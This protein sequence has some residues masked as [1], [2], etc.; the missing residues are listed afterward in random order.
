MMFLL[1]I[2]SVLGTAGLVAKSRVDHGKAV[3][4]RRIAMRTWGGRTPPLH[5]LDSCS[6]GGSCG[7]GCTCGS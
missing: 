6:C 1:A 4:N 7:G 5:T 3:A 2:V